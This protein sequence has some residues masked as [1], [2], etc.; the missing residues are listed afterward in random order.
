MDVFH[1]MDEAPRIECECGKGMSKVINSKGRD[2][3]K[4]FWHEHLDSKPI[5]IE[6][7]KQYQEECKRRGL[8]ARCL[9]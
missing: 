8:T 7:K 9:L 4:P 3:F 2:W 1:K 6:S 5:Y